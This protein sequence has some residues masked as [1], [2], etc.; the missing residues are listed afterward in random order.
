[1]TDQRSPGQGIAQWLG[2]AVLLAV[3]MGFGSTIL[4]RVLPPMTPPGVASG[5][6]TALQALIVVNLIVAAAL[7]LLAAQSRQRGWRLAVLV[8][9]A[10]FGLQTFMMILDGLWFNN[11]LQMS[12]LE[13]L[14]WALHDGTIA[15]A[16]GL[17]AMLLFRSAPEAEARFPK[18]FV[19]R[20]AL[21]TLVYVVLYFGAGAWAW[22]H[23]ALQTYY[24]HM[25]ISFGPTVAFQF[26]RG[27][28]WALIA[29]FLATGLR[30]S[31]LR[32]AAVMALLF[33]VLT[34]AQM[35]YPNPVMPWQVRQVHLIEVGVSEMIY[36]ILA[37]FI[38]LAG[39]ARRALPE[40]GRTQLVTG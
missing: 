31:L 39:S 25:Q 10:L 27:L 35:L 21:L 34:T 37:T 8:G 24:A 38:L 7:S 3:I 9:V 22:Q 33:A 17:A 30:G 6:L 20:I 13:Y 18:R 28:L 32:R 4:W 29:F 26:F 36:G 19:W 16:T 14:S 15:A 23:Q 2:K 11:T 12:P 1:M 5:P 40:S